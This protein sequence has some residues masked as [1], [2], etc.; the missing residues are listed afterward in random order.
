M[1]RLVVAAAWCLFAATLVSAQSPIRVLWTYPGPANPGYE[2]VTLSAVES[3][4]VYTVVKGKT[5]DFSTENG[6]FKET[7]STIVALDLASGRPNWSAESRWPILSPLLL[8][9]GR[10]IVHNGYGEVLCFDARNGKPLWKVEPELHPG[11]WD[12]RTMPS[13]LGERI[14][15]R[16][17]NE[18]VAR[19]LKDGKAVWRTPIEAVQNRRV[20]PAVAG[21]RIIVANAMDA[22]LVLDAE[23]GAVVWKK[24]LDGIGETTTATAAS[25]LVSNADRVFYWQASDGREIWTFGEPPMK[26]EFNA[27]KMKQ[28]NPRQLREPIWNLENLKALAIKG[29]AVYFLQKRVMYPQGAAFSL[30]IACHDLATTRVMHWYQPVGKEFQGFSLAGP[31]A[32]IVDGSTLT[33]LN[34]ADGKNVWEFEIPGEIRLQGQALALNGKILV[35]G[36]KGMTCLETGDPRI[37]GWTQSGGGP[38][39]AGTGR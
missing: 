10:L 22:V 4:V 20:F 15:L 31:L 23:T 25:V 32:L 13:A 19:G 18:I 17:E 30:E 38:A 11:S 33:A 21:G 1:K 9:A 36:T 35:V 5:W 26:F 3:G 14:Y 7:G 27:D 16:E 29:E 6:A 24:K 34:A 12:E 28:Q 8:T 39:R 37:S 2:W